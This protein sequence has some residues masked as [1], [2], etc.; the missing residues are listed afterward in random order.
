MIVK[1]LMQFR[2]FK[3]FVYKTIS[4]I[5]INYC[6]SP[7]S[8]GNTN[9][10]MAGIRFP[11][12]RLNINSQSISVYDLFRENKFVVMTY[13]IGDIDMIH[14]YFATKF[15]NLF[16]VKDINNNSDILKQIGFSD[17]FI[18][19]VRPDNYIAYIRSYLDL[20]EIDNY[21]IKQLQL[22]P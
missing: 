16:V 5:K 7:I 1:F 17:S 10:I 3:R 20:T 18:C 12:F 2:T 9:N 4:Q 22:N 13:N 6:N 8:L 19:I 21:L 14:K 15:N 11:Y